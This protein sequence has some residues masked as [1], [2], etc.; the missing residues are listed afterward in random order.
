[1]HLLQESGLLDRLDSIEA[2]DA[3]VDELSLVHDRR[4]VEAVK[5]VADEGGGWVD[6]D[7]L[8]MS[9]S[10]DAA[11][12]ASGGAIAALEAIIGGRVQSAFCLLR[13]PGHHA[14]PAQ[15]MGFC[16]FNNIA[17]AAA[18]ARLVHGLD[19]VAIVDFD[20]HHGNGTQDAFYADPSVLY[21]STHQYPFY[22]GTGAA[23]ETGAA[24]ARGYNIN[25]PLP[26]GCGDQ[27]YERAFAEI[28][29]PALDRFAPQ[30]IVVSAGFDAHFA[31]PLAS[32]QLS[33]DGYGRLVSMIASSA[34]R[35][36][37]G[38]MLLALEGGYD[39]VALPSCIKRTLETLLGIPPTP[40]PL[41]TIDV[42]EPASFDSRIAEVKRLHGL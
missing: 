33:V 19:R 16:I 10:Y 25:I 38:R 36:C 32:E 26:A 34:D 6:P 24:D 15:A 17:I 3:S 14:E 20:V 7:T 30:L 23:D 13:P 42:P 37:N 2:R 12:R 35:S 22:P 4:Y 9:R 31:D 39:L 28:V 41:G 8:I 21:T 27:A 5:R 40:D 29:V 11:T 1:M 18:V